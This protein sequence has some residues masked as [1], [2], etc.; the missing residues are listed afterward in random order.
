MAG[1]ETS[2]PFSA[3]SSA[4]EFVPEFQTAWPGFTIFTA[5]G[6]R[7]Q[8]CYA[9]RRIP[10]SRAASFNAKD[11]EVDAEAAMKGLS[12]CGLCENL[13]ALCV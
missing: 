13:C 11:A 7:R 5:M 8:L 1:S 9:V 3:V 12:L 2:H 4:S 6:D 10:P